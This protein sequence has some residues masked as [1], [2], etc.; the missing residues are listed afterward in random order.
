MPK[1]SGGLEKSEVWNRVLRGKVFS[2]L[3]RDAPLYFAPTR[4]GPKNI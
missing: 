3:T 4:T 2:N 1:E